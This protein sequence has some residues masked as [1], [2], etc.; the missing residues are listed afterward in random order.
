MLPEVTAIR[1]VTP[2]REGGSLPGIVEA[3]DLGHVRG[4]VHRRRPGPQ[5]ARRRGRRGRT[6]PP[7]RTC[8]CP[9]WCGSDFDPVIAL[10][11]PDEEVQDLLKASGG[12]NLGMDFLPGIGRLR[13]ARLRGEPR[14][15]RACRVVRRAG[16][17]RRPFLAQPQHADVARRP[18]AHRPRR[19]D[20]LA[21]QLARCRRLRRQAVRRHR[22]RAGPVRHRTSAVEAAAE[23]ARAAGDRGTAAEVDR[24]R[25]G[26]VAGGRTGLRHARRRAR[27][28]RGRAPARAATS[29]SGSLCRDRP[30]SPTRLRSGCVPGWRESSG[31][32]QEG[33]R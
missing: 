32:R 15:R 25:A 1:Y 28:L 4:E 8:R 29:P 12:L 27:R 13:P 18:V 14:T 10:G 26:R 23:R 9:T 19:H 17:Q 33:S 30:G 16:Q 22:P 6:G 5:V 24:R 20:D 21:P 3:D 31:H 7:P 11:E 2:L